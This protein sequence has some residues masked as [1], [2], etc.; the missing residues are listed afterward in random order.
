VTQCINLEESV[1]LVTYALDALFAALEAFFKKIIGFFFFGK[2]V[3]ELE[4][5]G[6]A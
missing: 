4:G 6:V 3:A 1:K 2:S 5:G